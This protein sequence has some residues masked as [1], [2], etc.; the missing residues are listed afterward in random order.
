MNNGQVMLMDDF[1]SEEEQLLMAQGFTME[2]DDENR[3]YFDTDGNLSNIFKKAW[4]FVDKGLAKLDKAVISPILNPV[5]GIAGK[6]ITTVG[7]IATDPKVLGMAAGF[8]TGQ[9]PSGEEIKSTLIGAAQNLT[10]QQQ[11][12]MGPV[13]NQEFAGFIGNTPGV[14]EWLMQR[15]SVNV[16]ASSPQMIPQAQ[17]IAQSMDML[18]QQVRNEMNIQN[19]PMM[20]RQPQQQPQTT[21]IDVGSILKNPIVLGVGGLVLLKVLK[22]F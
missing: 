4:N 2:E 17:Q 5:I 9:K 1:L 3:Y 11:Q 12:Q 22:V 15:T 19:P 7:N 14:Q 21:G 16:P 8:L 10:P 20:A 6:A 18:K 13:S